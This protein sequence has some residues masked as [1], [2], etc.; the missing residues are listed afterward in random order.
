[1]A[2]SEIG[3]FSEAGEAITAMHGLAGGRH[4]GANKRSVQSG[5]DKLVVGVASSHQKKLRVKMWVNCKFV[6][7]NIITYDLVRKLL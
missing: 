4:S 7:K 2:R 6:T 1:M 5:I 3:A